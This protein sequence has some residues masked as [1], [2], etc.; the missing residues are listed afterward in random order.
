MHLAP[1]LLE[2]RL[3]FLLLDVAPKL[4]AGHLDL[5]VVLVALPQVVG[6]GEDPQHCLQIGVGRH[7]D[8]GRNRDREVHQRV[9]D[10][11]Q[12]VPGPGAI[13]QTVGIR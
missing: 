2:H 8:R 9:P 13:D 5:L 11:C 1:P 7:R 10:E 3:T 12:R 4:V 6:G